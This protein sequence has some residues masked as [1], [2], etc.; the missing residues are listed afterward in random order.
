MEGRARYFWALA[1]IA[2][3]WTFL[4]SFLDKLLGLGFSTVAENAWIRGGSPTAGFLQFG[5]AGPLTDFYQSLAGK[6]I[7]DWLFMFGLL[8]LGVALLL[9][10]LMHIA[11]YGGAVFVLLLWSAHLPPENNPVVDQHIIYLFVLLGL[12]ASGAGRTWGLGSWW[13]DVVGHRRWLE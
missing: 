8:G 10:V 12:M 1:R 5:T 9:G 13:S 4:W 2:L 7:V 11:G 6:P 3:G